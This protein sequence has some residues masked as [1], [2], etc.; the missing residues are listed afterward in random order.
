MLDKGK[1]LLIS[2]RAACGSSPSPVTSPSSPAAPQ[3]AVMIPILVHLAGNGNSTDLILKECSPLT[4]T[5]L[6]PEGLLQ[7]IAYVLLALEISQAAFDLVKGKCIVRASWGEPST[8]PKSKEREET[9]KKVL[10]GDEGY[11]APLDAR[12]F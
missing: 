2:V 9:G 7:G 10:W 3:L 4:M 11:R 5:Y 6:R 1:S 12:E 8:G